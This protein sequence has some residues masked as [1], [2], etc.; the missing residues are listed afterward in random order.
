MAYISTQKVAEIRA[1]LK[2]EF[3]EIKFSVRRDGYTA[4][5]VS[6]LKAPYEFRPNGK[7]DYY[8]LTVNKHWIDVDGYNNLDKLKRIIEICNEGNHDNSNVMIDYFD[9]GWYLTLTIGQSNK[10]FELTSTSTSKVA[11]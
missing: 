5:N 4:V 11:A 9:V 3:P 1:N 6:I 8:F 7:N 2:K 10:P